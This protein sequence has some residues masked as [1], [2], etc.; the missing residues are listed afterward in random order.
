MKLLAIFSFLLFANLMNAQSLKEHR[1]Q[2]RVLLVLHTDTASELAEQQ[3]TLLQA[4]QKELEERR[5]VMY[6]IASDESNPKL[7]RIFK[8]YASET[9]ELAVLLIG[10]DG[11]VKMRKQSLVQPQEIFTLIDGMPMRRAALRRKQQN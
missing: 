3:I 9:S 5:L 1:W 6:R 8:E 10:L 2:D 11:G 7:A 4:K